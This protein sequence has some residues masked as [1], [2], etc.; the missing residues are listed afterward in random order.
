MLD[1]NTDF[2]N[3]SFASAAD[4][5]TLPSI[6]K[7][8]SKTGLKL[9]QSLLLHLCTRFFQMY[10]GMFQEEIESESTVKWCIG[11]KKKSV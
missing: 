10:S 1:R 4:E 2:Q 6:S 11:K 7:Y 3:S 5:V 8:E 9:W